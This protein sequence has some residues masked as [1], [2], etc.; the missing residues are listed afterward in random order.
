LRLFDS[1]DPVNLKAMKT[2][3]DV[4]ESVESLSLDEQENLLSI[5]DLRLRE[6]RRTELFQQVRAARRQY[7]AGRCQKA[8]PDEI[9]DQI[10]T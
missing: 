3:G 5:L 8:S 1:A 2:F 6:R 7:A 4:L 10:F 9:I